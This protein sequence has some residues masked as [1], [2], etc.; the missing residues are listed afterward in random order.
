MTL[1]KDVLNNGLNESSGFTSD[2]SS[3]KIVRKQN[4]YTLF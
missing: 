3:G 1:N 2:T 4:A